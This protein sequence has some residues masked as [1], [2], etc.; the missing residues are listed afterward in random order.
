MGK[1]TTKGEK[2]EEMQKLNRKST[3]TEKNQER[4]N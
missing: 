3:E 2:G 1:K 4:T